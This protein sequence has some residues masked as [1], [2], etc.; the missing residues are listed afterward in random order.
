MTQKNHNYKLLIAYDGTNYCGWQIQ[1][2]GDTIQERL[3]KILT[4]LL[5]ED[6]HLIGA[7][8]TD[9]GVHAYGQVAHFKTQKC[10]DCKKILKA[11]NGLLPKDI[12]VLHMR[13]VPMHFHSQYSAISKTYHYNLWLDPITNP[14]KRHYTTWVKQRMDISLLKEAAQ[15][16][17]GTHDFTS[18]ANSATEGSAAKGATRTI[19]RLDVIEQDGGVRLEFQANGFLYRMVRNIV[20]T[21]IEVAQKKRPVNSLIQIIES[22]DRRLAGKS[23]AAT[24][25]FLMNVDYPDDLA[26]PM[27]E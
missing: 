26:L 10:L 6:I 5:Q 23:A 21:L 24:G 17:V 18:F 15:V 19:Q 27:M 7:G 1:P 8:R 2:N 25:L 14:M 12:R 20:G 11:L 13:E 4:S 3:I 9:A 16:F 22:K